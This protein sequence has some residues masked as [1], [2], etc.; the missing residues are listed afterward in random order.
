MTVGQLDIVLGACLAVLVCTAL[1]AAWF[2][3]RLERET[4]TSHNRRLMIEQIEG[5]ELADD[6]ELWL[7]SQTPEDA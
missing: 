4:N 2:A 1:W 5:E 6:V 3:W 7:A